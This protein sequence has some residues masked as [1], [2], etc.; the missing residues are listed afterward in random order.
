MGDYD[1]IAHYNGNEMIRVHYLYVLTFMELRL[2]D[3]GEVSQE[4]SLKRPIWK[5]RLS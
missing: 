3:K 2:R 1:N 4:I 5:S